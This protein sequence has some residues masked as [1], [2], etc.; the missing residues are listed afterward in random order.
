MEKSEQH[1]SENLS[2]TSGKETQSHKSARTTYSEPLLVDLLL[3]IFSRVPTKSIA[4]FRCVSKFWQYKFGLPY[5]TEL[6]L[7]K[8]STRPRLLFTLYSIY[9]GKLFF[10]SAPQPHNPDKNS[11]LVATRYHMSSRKNVPC[12][13][14]TPV[15]GLTFLHEGGE[16]IRKVIC[17][18]ITG[19]FLTLPRV[20]LKSPHTENAYISR[21]CFG[22]DPISKQ[23]KLLCMISSLCEGPNTHQVLTLESGKRFWRRIGFAFDFVEYSR[24]HGQICIDGVL[25]F[26]ANMEDT[27]V[28]VCF[29]VRSEK[30]DFINLDKDMMKAHEYESLTLINYKGKLGIHE[31]INNVKELVLWVMEDAGNHKWSKQTYQVPTSIREKLF[32]GMTAT[33]DIVWSSY[34]NGNKSKPYCVYFYNLERGT[35]TSVTIQGFEEFECRSVHTFIHYV[36][37]LKFM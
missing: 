19:K 31:R 36:E 23:F 33:G 30:F 18:P 1:F 37:N 14:C 10:Y 3:D 34:I 5:F 4:R 32:V 9:D 17:N 21:F 11:S 22:Y 28:I 25:Y 13:Y 2:I 7:S 8:S 6:F 16:V 20:V 12:V 15:C 26:G 27:S 35:F 24:V 29:D